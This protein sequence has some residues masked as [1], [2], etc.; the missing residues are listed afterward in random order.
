MTKRS[1]PYKSDFLKLGFTVLRDRSGLVRSQCLQCMQVLANESLKENKLKRHLN[2]VH[3][4]FVD[5]PLSFWKEKEANVKRMRLDA[6]SNLVTV[7]LEKVTKAS[8]EVAWRIARCKK[9]HNIGEELVKPAALAMVRTVCGDEIA[10]KLE[11]VQLSDNSIKR[12]IDCMSQDILEQVVHGLKQ[13]RKFVIQIDES[14]DI[15]D[16][17]QLMVFVRY[18]TDD[19][20]V[21][22]F[23]FCE[24]LRTTTT[25]QDIFEMVNVFF[26]QQNLHWMDCCAVCAD[27]APAMMG[28]RVGFCTRVKEVNP[29]V[30]II[31]CFLHRDNLAT[32]EIQPELHSVLKDAIQIVNF[33]KA[34]AL[35]SR[36]FRVMCEEMGSEHQHLLYHS[37]VR[38]LSRGKILS[39]VMLLRT[40]IEIFLREKKHSLADRFKDEA[41]LAKLAYLSDIFQHLNELSTEMQGRNRTIVDI[42]EKI[43]SFKRKLA[44]WREKMSKGKIAAFPGLNE[45]LED[46]AEVSI[47][48]LVEIFQEHLA[49]LQ[50]EM[51]RYL[52][53]NVDLQKH[54]WVRNPFDLDVHEVGNDVD[55]FQEELLDLQ[56]NQVLQE[57]FAHVSW[58]QFWAQLRGKPVL[59]REA[60]KALLPF[61]TTYLC[62]AG[63]S[64]LVVIKTRARNR[65]DPQHD[66][67]CA[68]SINIQPR[69]TELTEKMQHQ[70]SH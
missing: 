55:G 21:E 7:S 1:L 39:R 54:S 44:L 27:G 64:S 4:N 70:G 63:F 53:Q 33:I 5:K 20:I 30:V 47:K 60:E 49:K 45:F 67:S 52:P 42:G 19:N 9:P 59:S 32:K 23:L 56:E 34:R 16:N 31:H 14:V 35:N 15:E 66:L 38:W 51:D 58:S 25:G 68:L 17:P 61:P 36:L 41:W 22:E 28:S 43:S 12:R 8:F 65:L 40:E 24:P 46:A 62:E 26:K 6:P 69:I 37:E 29:D 48:D 10:K 18:K 3:P 13:A 57:K 50:T 11:L 2:T